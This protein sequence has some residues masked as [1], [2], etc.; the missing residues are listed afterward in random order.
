VL[1]WRQEQPRLRVQP[2]QS[3]PTGCKVVNSVDLGTELQHCDNRNMHRCTDAAMRAST[4]PPAHVENAD[5]IS[6]SALNEAQH[7]C[8]S[9]CVMIGHV[10]WIAC[11]L[12]HKHSARRNETG[13]TRLLH[14]FCRRDG[15]L[16][17][18]SWRWQSK[19]GGGGG[20]T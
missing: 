14:N 5:A 16:H 12:R 6:A 20:G 17:A 10:P 9:D 3:C 1:P 11:M 19:R 15:S 8:D 13:A 2:E 7:A 4:L 18:M